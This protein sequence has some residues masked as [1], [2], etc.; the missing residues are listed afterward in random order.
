M[1]API[2]PSC[3]QPIT[4]ALDAPYG[5]W[6]WDDERSKYVLRTAAPEG[7]V[8]TSPWVHWDCMRELRSFHPQ[9]EFAAR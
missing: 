2:C 6:E 4:R 9:N 8:D 1:S 5:W 3:D 7:H